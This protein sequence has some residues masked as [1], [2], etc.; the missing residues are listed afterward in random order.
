MVVLSGSKTFEMSAQDFCAAVSGYGR[1]HIDVGTGDG[2]NIYKLASKNPDVFYIGIDPVKENM[3][4]TSKK[5]SKKP[6]KGGL[7]NV[8]L[9]IASA[10][11]LPS[12]LCGTADHVS[13]LF[14]WGSLLECVIKPVHDTLSNI[15]ELA[16]SGARFEFV[17][18][19]SDSYE[20]GE[21]LRRGLPEISRDYFESGDYTSALRASGFITDGVEEYDNEYVKQFN[22]QWAKRLAF[23]RKR[24]FYRVYGN[25]IK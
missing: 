13:V 17:T 1:I 21:M 22:S 7:S 10:E 12:E 2:R 5:L 6:A 14:P 20:E 19:Y 11:S 15:A 4:E 9:V 23:G 16:K 8:M 3:Y 24:S 18:T 25:I